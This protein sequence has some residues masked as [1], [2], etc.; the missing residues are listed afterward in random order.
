[1][2][3]STRSQACS[4]RGTIWSDMDGALMSSLASPLMWQI[5][6]MMMWCILNK[7]CSILVLSAIVE[8]VHRNPTTSTVTRSGLDRYQ[9]LA[10][11][12]ELY[13][14]VNVSGIGGADR[15]QLSKS[16]NSWSP[17]MIAGAYLIRGKCSVQA[18]LAR[19]IFPCLS[20][21]IQKMYGLFCNGF[22]FSKHLR[23]NLIYL[24]GLK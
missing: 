7:S 2:I 22:K 20:V 23:A 5:G 17:M 8:V 12:T 6:C 15:S 4:N 13:R 19:M 9:L 21:V 10:Y 1:M 3:C 24:H 11:S 18:R 14:M 16:G